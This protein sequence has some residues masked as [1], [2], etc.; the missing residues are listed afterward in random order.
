MQTKAFVYTELQNS[1]LFA[2][3]PWEAL[4]RT[5]LRQPG[6]IDKTWLSGT[7]SQSLGGFY[8]FDSLVNAQRFVT[9]YFPSEARGFN[10]AQSSRI[11]DAEVVAQASRDMN[12][13]HFGG[14]LDMPPG[15]FVYTEVQLHLPFDQVPWREMN[16]LLKQQPGILGKTWL[17]GIN[18]HTP[19]GFY[20]FDTVENATAFAVD[21]FPT[22]AA[23]LNA[24]FTARV[25]DAGPVEQAS[26]QLRSPFFA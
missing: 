3:A 8:A 12:S 23:N 9:G 16:P 18:T 1:V 11:F 26:R 13:V 4:N 2:D 7:G 5:L 20:A 17:S 15:A 14:Q 25:F 22:E 24:A 19:G 6:L 10:L 21:Y